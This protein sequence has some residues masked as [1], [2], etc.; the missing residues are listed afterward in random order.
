MG[1]STSGLMSQWAK[2]PVG[3]STSGKMSVGKSKMGKCQWANVPNPIK[4][5]FGSKKLKIF[6]EFLLKDLLNLNILHNK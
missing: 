2:V 6:E 1:E 3:K 4:H 5:Q